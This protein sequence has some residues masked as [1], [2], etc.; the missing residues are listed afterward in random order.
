VTVDY[1]GERAAPEPVSAVIGKFL[2][3][4][5]SLADIFKR[6]LRGWLYGLLGLVAGLAF[7]VYSVWTTAPSYTVIIG[8][9][10]TDKDS[11]VSIGGDSGGALGAIASLV[12][13]GGG[14]VP[15]FTRFVASL[16]STGTAKIMERDYDM[17]CRTYSGDCDIKTHTWREHTGF[18]GWVQKMVAEVAHLPA[19]D[20]PR[21]ATDLASY[22][23]GS[24]IMT[25]DKTTHVLTLTMES[26]DPKFA[27]EYL[28]TLVRATNDN[29]KAEDRASIQPYV[30][31][32]NAKLASPG[33]NL[34][35]HDALSA[36]L[37]EQERQLML[38]SVNVPY[39][40][41]IQDGPNVTSSNS[42]LRMLLVDSL[43]GL[44]LGFGLGIAV[45]TWAARRRR[46]RG[47]AWQH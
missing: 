26:S 11:G 1:D 39:A 16:Y 19:P 41:T 46:M 10:P 8:L 40:A 30:D 47:P 24:V 43:L 29:L 20:R 15:K 2:R 14:A 22:T 13:V 5:Y 36:L 28:V 33:L 27:S 17:V 31:Y 44:V 3:H 35:Q 4:S 6:A 45:N 34:T 42:A 21:T 25:S 37:L 23:E 12:G 18:E 9:L 38:S 32:L 7:G